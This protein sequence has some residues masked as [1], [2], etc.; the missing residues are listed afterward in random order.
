MRALASGA[1]VAFVLAN[2]YLLYLT[3]PLVSPQ[4]QLIFHLPGSAVPLFAA[5][6]VDVLALTLLLALA[7]LWSRN[8]PRTR[9]LLWAVLL[10]PLPSVLLATVATFNGRPANFV[11]M[12]LCILIPAA[13]FSFTIARLGALAPTFRRSESALITTFSLISP[14]GL[15]LFGQLLWNG[16][17][18]RHLN[19]AFLP[20]APALSIAGNASRQTSQTRIVWLILDELSYRQIFP[21]RQPGLALPSFDRLASTST[22]FT[23]TQAAAEYTRIAVPSLLTG[24][25]LTATAPTADGQ[26]LLLR[27]RGAGHRRTLDPADTVFADVGNT[28]L[29]TGIAGWYEPY[30]RLLPRVLNKC[31]WTYRDDLPEGLSAGA[32]FTANVLAP[33]RTVAKAAR[34]LGDLVQTT[35][36]EDQA[37]RLDVA[38]H[39]ADYRDLYAAGDRLLQK[40]HTG[41]LLL[42]MPIPH[43]WGF[44]DRR[45]ASFPPYRTSY[46]DNLVLA[47][48]YVAHIRRLME[49]DGT[50]NGTTLIVMGDHGWRAHDV[51][52]PS[53]FWTTEEERASQGGT[54]S[55]R[56]ALFLKLPGQQIPAFLNTPFVA[57]RTRAL[58]NA[59]IAGKLQTPKDLKQWIE[60]AQP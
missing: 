36:Q 39:A 40:Q 56:P 13:L 52:R 22:V 51:W 46:L 38:R 31:F 8:L 25:P 24:L 47:D 32:S 43:P 35:P 33:L 54:L 34:L 23:H 18:T 58:I 53:G 60:K 49:A 1:A 12:S 4:H 19:P 41:L 6:I 2:L 44:Y 48:L 26:H 37:G 17:Q 15:L 16:W 21:G 7:L 29:P 59:L 55:D 10:L 9:L 42:H 14:A 57:W 45:T 11:L 5:A 27:P 50:W 3:G 30:C 28:G 20:R